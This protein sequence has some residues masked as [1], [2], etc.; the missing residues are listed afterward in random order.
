[1][2]S[3]HNTASIY[4]AVLGLITFVLGA[5]DVLVWAGL[6][7]GMDFGIMQIAGDD[8]FRWAWGGLVVAFA[9]ILMIR[10]SRNIGEIP[11]YSEALLG[12]ILVWMVAGCD[13]FAMICEN[14]PAGE[15]APEF[16]NSI[17]GFIGG[18][19]PP[20]APAVILLPFTLALLYF[21]YVWG[22]AEE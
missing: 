7:G 10:G 22:F 20:Y 14:I 21:Y 19:A 15:E 3:Q 5:A 12:A 13:I 16:L 2:N 18:F 6:T 4:V 8:F 1:M 9:G 17:G 11:Q